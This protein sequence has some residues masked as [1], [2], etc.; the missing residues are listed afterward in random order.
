MLQ[1]LTIEDYGLIPRA[2]I[3]FDSGATIFTGE[4]GSGKTMVLGA[5]AFVLGERASP[6]IIRKDRP[7]ARVSLEFDPGSTLRARLAED[8]FEIDAD[9]YAR[10]DREIAAQSGKSSLRLNSRPATA[11][12][13]RE[14]SAHVVDIAGQHEAQRLLAPAYH[15]ELLDRFAGETAVRARE[16]L[17]Q[18]Y[19]EHSR[20]ADER[21]A[22]D[23]DER[24]SHEQLAFAEFSLREIEGVAPQAG[25][26]ELLAQRRRVLENAEK[27]AL[28]LQTAHAWLTSAEGAAADAAGV[29]A[30]ALRAVADIGGDFTEMAQAAAALQSD[31]NELAMRIARQMDCIEFDANELEQ[32]NARLEAL[33]TVKRK[34]GGTLEAVI[35]R[36]DE[37]RSTLQRIENRDER[38]LQ[39]QRQS[40]QA[41]AALTKAAGKLTAVRQSAAG[42]LAK[43]VQRELRELAMPAA[44][45]R[46]EF[47]T[48]P[49]IGAGGA[50]AAQ[51]LF[52][53]NAGETA[54]PLARIASGGELSRVLLALI[55][56][57]AAS[58]GGGALVFDEIDAGVGGATASAVGARLGRL[59]HDAQVVCVTH[60]AQ[61]AS[62]ADR[63]YVLEK[64]EQRGSTTIE[65]IAISNDAARTAEVARMLS[66]ET[67]DAAL[68][69]ARTLLKTTH[70]RRTP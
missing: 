24:Q 1:K 36:L 48:L 60:L 33:D 15:L 55:V 66:G 46:V 51:F 17:V 11:A 70:D 56:V 43:R 21:S 50:E 34:Y 35:A 40:E 20:L 23:R 19:R 9:E 18:R 47:T 37:F 30:G 16:E 57:L 41:Q 44:V 7:R 3:L 49:E 58:R 12:Y 31:I 45:F 2:E 5:L 26:D 62:W 8:G 64:H 27:I 6:E 38:R 68:K 28:A 52:A 29:A 25:E 59:A 53:A 54:R 13:I 42:D 39:L 61:I 32:V 10:I 4:T 22:F 67:H 63:H 69:H 14:V 65:V